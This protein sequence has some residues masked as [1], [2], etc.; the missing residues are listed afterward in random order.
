M[1]L[2]PPNVELVAQAWI[3][4]YAGIPAGQVATSLPKVTTWTNDGFLQVRAVVGGSS[5][6]TLPQRR[7]SVV[8]LDAWG[9]KASNTVRPLWGVASVLIERVRIATFNGTQGFGKPLSMPIS[10]YLPARPL[11]AYL[12][13][14]PTRVEGDPSGFARFTCDLAVDWTV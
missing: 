10:G 5:E 1:T 6:P 13:R 7:T 2:A 11:A 14:E 8:Q 9:A 12:T 4:A 3:A